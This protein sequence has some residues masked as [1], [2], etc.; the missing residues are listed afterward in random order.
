ML[1]RGSRGS[2]DRD[3]NDGGGV[4]KD[5]GGVNSMV[6]GEGPGVEARAE[7]RSRVTVIVILMHYYYSRG[8]ILSLYLF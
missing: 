4:N 8:R 3:T 1:S 2:T 6:R 7:G 5:G